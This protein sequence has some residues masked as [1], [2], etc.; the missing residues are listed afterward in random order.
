MDRTVNLP[1]LLN[2]SSH[3]L[4]GPRGTGKSYLIRQQIGA[5]AQ[6][7]DL[8]DSS[9]YLRL[10]AHPEDLEPMLS[11]K[12]VVID[13]VQR[14]PELL[15]EVHRLIETK[16]IHFLLTGSSARKLK[17]GGANLLAGRALQSWLQ[18][19]TWKELQVDGRFVLEKYLLLGGLPKAYLDEV[20]QKYLFS[21]VDTYLIEEIQAEA[22]VKNLG[23]FSRFLEQAAFSNGQILNF[24][25]LGNDAQVSPNT[26]RDYYQL[27]EDTLV[28]FSLE[29]WT[30]SR[31]RKAVQTAKFYLFDIGVVN[32]IC[33]VKAMPPAGDWAG[34]A[35]EH[36]LAQ[37]IRAYLRYTDQ[38]EHFRFWRSAHQ[39]EVDFVIGDEIAI[40]VK[41]TK[42]TTPRDHKGLLALAEEKKWKHLFVVSND[43]VR[44][45]F[46]TGI[47]QLHWS[48]FLTQLWD[49]SYL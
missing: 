49:G 1:E 24:T 29:P 7:I 2:K 17:R 33:N 22:L 41:F 10:S 4:F 16:G 15:N 46:P 8:L 28:G 19:L 40:E 14:I 30:K 6:V 44:M 37:E 20:G 9:I 42:H 36:F 35:F 34:R 21:Y 47:V 25:K 31:K 39:Q 26:V 23:N 43:P 12:T 11:S 48:D 5:S 38:R 18:P 45:E 13:E 3:F 27:L 32:A